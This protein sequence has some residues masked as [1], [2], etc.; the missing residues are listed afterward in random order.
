[1]AFRDVK[2]A[3]REGLGKVRESQRVDDVLVQYCYDILRGFHGFEPASPLEKKKWFKE[4]EDKDTGGTRVKMK[5]TEGWK[6]KFRVPG[7][8]LRVTHNL[9]AS[10]S[11]AS[12][13][14]NA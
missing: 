2:D 12:G 1:M 8:S 14:R 13:N 4:K 11:A 7:G 9:V 3:L 5:N 10:R 6:M